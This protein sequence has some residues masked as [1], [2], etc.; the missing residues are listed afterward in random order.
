MFKEI[1]KY[2]SE[3]NSYILKVKKYIN[4]RT[5]VTDLLTKLVITFGVMLVVGGLYLIMTNPSGSTQGAQ[6]IVSTVN[7]IPGIPFSI[8][9]L[10]NVGATSVGLVS[11]FIGIDLLLV[12]LGFWV[13]SRIAR[14]IGLTIFILAALF[15]FVQFMFVGIM[16]SPASIIELLIDASFI[17]FIS[18]KFD[19]QN[20]PLI[21]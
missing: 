14:F 5:L 3:L 4:D 10:V 12:G 8:G 2:L 21:K 9:S 6:S 7:W 16:G 20:V 1:K 11:W 15:Q 18:L 13:R 19:S 17:Y